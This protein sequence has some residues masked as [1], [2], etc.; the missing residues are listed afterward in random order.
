MPGGLRV[1]YHGLSCVGIQFT[2]ILKLSTSRRVQLLICIE[3]GRRGLC[4]LQL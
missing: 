1:I 3:Q 2:T 4:Y